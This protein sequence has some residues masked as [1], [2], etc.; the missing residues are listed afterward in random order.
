M[1][2]PPSSS[3]QFS[4]SIGGEREVC[5]SGPAAARLTRTDPTA[6]SGQSSAMCGPSPA[7][8]SGP[9]YGARP[10]LPAPL[11]YPPSQRSDGG[12]EGETE[13][14]RQRGRTGRYREKMEERAFKAPADVQTVSICLLTRIFITGKSWMSFDQIEQ[15]LLSHFECCSTLIGAQK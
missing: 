8:T 5:P 9:I 11:T 1:W 15:Q 7:S 6:S 10:V 2:C 12:R 4:Y 14:Q 13:R 3:L